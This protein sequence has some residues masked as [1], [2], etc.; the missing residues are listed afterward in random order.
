V[1]IAWLSTSRP[2]ARMAPRQDAATGHH[3]R[4]AIGAAW[5]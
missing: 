3:H 5:L 2:C 1:W 4:L